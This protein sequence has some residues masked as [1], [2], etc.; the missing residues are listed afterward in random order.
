MCRLTVYCGPRQAVRPLVY[1]GDHSLLRQSWEPRELLSGSVNADGYGVVWHDGRSWV[2]IAQPVPIWQDEDLETL[3]GSVQTSIGLAALRN[4]TPGIPLGRSGLPPLTHG[5]HAFVLNGFVEGFRSHWMR[6]FRETLPD[7]LYG[8][9]R[10]SSDSETLF[11]MAIAR[12]EGGATLG[13]AL[14][15]LSSFVSTA[16]RADG[17]VAQLT[18]AF[19]DSDGVSVVRTGSA[20]STNTLYFT[21]GSSLMAGGALVASEVLEREANWEAVPPH[22]LVEIDPTGAVKVTPI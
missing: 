16:V 2:R 8:T 3:L 18:M 21:N 20:A 12:V 19:A 10:G 11:M 15:D 4:V 9:L 13:E 7:H 5:R 22:H 6:G 17:M 1:G 14:R